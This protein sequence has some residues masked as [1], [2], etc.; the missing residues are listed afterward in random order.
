MVKRT[1]L[2]FSLVALWGCNDKLDI[3]LHRLNLKGKIHTIKSYIYTAHKVKE[4]IIG[5]PDTS[6][7][8]IEN[9]TKE[10][11]LSTTE[12]YEENILIQKTIYNKSID[13]NTKQ[14]ITYDRKGNIQFYKVIKYN[15]KKHIIDISTLNDQKQLQNVMIFQYNKERVLL[16]QDIYNASQKRIS[17][18]TFKKQGEISI[19]TVIENG[20]KKKFHRRCNEY[21]DVIE[22]ILN[23]GTNSQTVTYQYTYDRTNNWTKRISG[24]I[25]IDPNKK[26]VIE[27]IIT[28]Y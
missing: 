10:G 3:D 23:Y 7:Y 18:T 28:Y 5:E 12:Y 4:D 2:L 13:K 21:K 15:K 26:Q 8:S 9:F 14:S 22:D 1:I 20:E 27:R 11:Q 17:E 25:N 24:N 16:K 19:I 6:S